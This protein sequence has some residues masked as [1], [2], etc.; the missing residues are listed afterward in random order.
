MLS[1]LIGPS[2]ANQIV[3]TGD[4][5]SSTQLYDLGLINI[6]SKKGQIK[7]DSMELANLL[8]LKSPS[9]LSSIKKIFNNYYSKNNQLLEY[10]QNTFLECIKNLKSP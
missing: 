4:K 5:Y 2:I 3:M 9:A 7:K 10:E 8:S 1:C 6:L